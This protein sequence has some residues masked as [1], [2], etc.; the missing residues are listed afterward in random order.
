VTC[1]VDRSQRLPRAASRAVKEYPATLN[2][3]A[4]GVATE[5]EPKLLN[6]PALSDALLL[7]QPV[8]HRSRSVRCP[9]VSM[10]ALATSLDRS[11]AAAAE[12]TPWMISTGSGGQPSI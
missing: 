1:P 7:D 2:Y 10:S 11:S 3:A 8:Q 9:A 4:F 5:V 12:L 6:G